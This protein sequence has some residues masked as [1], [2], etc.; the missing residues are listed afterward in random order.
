MFFLL[1]WGGRAGLSQLLCLFIDALKER[2]AHIFSNVS[3]QILKQ[4]MSMSCTHTESVDR[5]KEGIGYNALC[6]VGEGVKGALPW[7]VELYKLSR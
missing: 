7:C 4:V 6:R 2:D 5:V 3:L 1:Q